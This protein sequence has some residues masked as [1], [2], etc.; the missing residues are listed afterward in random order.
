MTIVRCSQCLKE[1]RRIPD[2]GD[3]DELQAAAAVWNGAVVRVSSPPAKLDEG[4]FPFLTFAAGLLIGVGSALCWVM[5][6]G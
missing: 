6:V 5:W 4:L 2:E 1:P 3:G